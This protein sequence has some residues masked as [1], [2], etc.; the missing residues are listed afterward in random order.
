MGSYD[1]DDD[2]AVVAAALETRPAAYS[3]QFKSAIETDTTTTSSQL[4]V[5]FFI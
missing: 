5:D 2:D 1:D 4:I 3:H